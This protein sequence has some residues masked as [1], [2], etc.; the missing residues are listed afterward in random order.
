MT[1]LQKGGASHIDTRAAHTH[2]H[3]HTEHTSWLNW[4]AGLNLEQAQKVLVELKPNT[5]SFIADKASFSR[6]GIPNSAC[7]S[8]T[9]TDTHAQTH[10]G[11]VISETADVTV[12]SA[13]RLQGRSDITP[14]KESFLFTL[15]ARP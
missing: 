13:S 4:R 11:F 8:Q 5:A 6:A 12:C 9:H 2:T 10:A 14:T 3:I 15:S 7:I 1:L